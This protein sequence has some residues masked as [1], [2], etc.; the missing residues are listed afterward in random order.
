VCILREYPSSRGFVI[1]NKPDDR[2]VYE[3]Y[4]ELAMCVC[5]VYPVDG[6]EGSPRRLP[7]S[8]FVDARDGPSDGSAR[9]TSARGSSGRV[10]SGRLS[11]VDRRRVA[12]GDDDAKDIA[13]GWR[14]R[15][16]RRRARDGSRTSRADD[17]D[18]DDDGGRVRVGGRRRDRCDGARGE[19]GDDD[20]DDGRR[21]RATVARRARTADRSREVRVVVVVVDGRDD[22]KTFGIAVWVL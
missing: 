20:G 22:E 8:S 10:G 2:Y 4:V 14:R 5:V 1:S 21:R 7:S 9:A 13:L 19:R 18:D 3:S 11:R 15:R 17:D 16:R 12:R 6:P